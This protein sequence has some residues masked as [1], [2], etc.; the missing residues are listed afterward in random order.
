M[1]PL[2]LLPT[3]TE[4]V[5]HMSLGNNQGVKFRHGIPITQRKAML[6]T[7]D[8]SLRL[9]LTEWAGFFFST[10]HLKGRVAFQNCRIPLIEK[11]L[12]G[13][14]ITLL[15]EVVPGLIRLP[16][17]EDEGFFKGV[18]TPNEVFIPLIQAF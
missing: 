15:Q 18:V 3:Q 12:F 8:N 1:N 2:Q 9:E 16:C 14:S 10:H 5:R 13:K 17:L 4:I 7:V 6:V 11:A